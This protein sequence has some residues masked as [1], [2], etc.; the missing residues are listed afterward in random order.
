[1]AS[2]GDDP[3]LRYALSRAE[4]RMQD[5]LAQRPPPFFVQRQ[6]DLAAVPAADRVRLL[7]EVFPDRHD[8]RSFE[9]LAMADAGAFTQRDDVACLN[10]YFYADVRAAARGVRRAGARSRRPRPRRGVEEL[11]YTASELAGDPLVEKSWWHFVSQPLVAIRFDTAVMSEAAS[12]L[13]RR[14]RAREDPSRLASLAPG[15]GQSRAP[16]LPRCATTRPRSRPRSTRRSASAAADHT[17]SSSIAP[18]RATRR[19][20][21]LAATVKFAQRSPTYQNLSAH[22]KSP[23]ASSRRRARCA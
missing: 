21:H 5:C 4:A 11:V 18:S 9:M 23:V 19:A 14:A 2:V 17:T 15:R 7:G 20:L 8:P 13:G 16:R 3:E 22:I 10:R 12:L 6:L 1:M